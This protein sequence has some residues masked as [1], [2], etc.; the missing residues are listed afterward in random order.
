MLESSFTP[1]IWRVGGEGEDEEKPNLWDA[2]HCRKSQLLMI[3]EHHEVLLLFD[4][5]LQHLKVSCHDYLQDKI[6]AAAYFWRII[7]SSNIWN[8]LKTRKYLN[9]QNSGLGI[10][11][12]E[13]AVASLDAKF[14]YY[15][16]PGQKDTNVPKIVYFLSKG[17]MR[18]TSDFSCRQFCVVRFRNH[19]RRRG[20]PFR[21]K[22][23]KNCFYFFIFFC[24]SF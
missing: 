7:V 17:D 12:S 23:G 6:A 8:Q 4:P 16:A 21:K 5:I 20:K 11:K 10:F 22:L 2:S 1:G 19:I 15:S 14:S 18:K 24:F 3:I 9:S 13:I